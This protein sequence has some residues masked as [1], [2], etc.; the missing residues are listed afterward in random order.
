MR[1][2]AKINNALN[3]LLLGISTRG[4]LDSFVS[5]GHHYATLD[6][7]AVKTLL[8]SLD[9]QSDDVFMDIGCGKGR[10]MATCSAY[11]IAKQVIGIEYDKTLFNIGTH[12]IEL[13]RKRH[14]NNITIIYGDATMHDYKDVTAVYMFNPFGRD[15]LSA[16]VKRVLQTN[17]SESLKILYVNP[18]HR[19]VFLN[20]FGSFFSLENSF[21]V[22][23]HEAI[24][25]RKRLHTSNK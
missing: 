17:T 4:V 10:V 8:H 22:S 24:I 14:R 21:S 19:D 5:D 20:D 3:D 23:Q 13:F 1:I 25:I 11:F 12:N 6:Y 15:T 9:L 2:F 18:A 16:F 7:D